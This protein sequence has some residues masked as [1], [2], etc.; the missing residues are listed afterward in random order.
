MMLYRGIILGVLLL[1]GTVAAAPKR[2]YSKPEVAAVHEAVA[3]MKRAGKTWENPRSW[4]SEG[5]LSRR[6]GVQYH[7]VLHKMAGVG[8]Y[9][10]AEIVGV[11]RGRDRKW[12]PVAGNRSGFRADNVRI[13]D[14]KPVRGR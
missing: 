3:R 4:Q 12:R 10:N 6:S 1:A 5:V 11:Y 7:H 8:F 13:M 14:G 9:G 2:G